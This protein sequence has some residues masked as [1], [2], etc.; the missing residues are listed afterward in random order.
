MTTVHI[1]K[2]RD[3]GRGM[4]CKNQISII[5]VYWRNIHTNW[6]K[7]RKNAVTCWVIDYLFKVY[8]VCIQAWSF[9]LCKKVLYCHGLICRCSEKRLVL[10][11]NKSVLEPRV[12]ASHPT[13]P[14]LIPSLQLTME[15]DLGQVSPL[16]W[17]LCDLSC[18]TVNTRTCKC[19]IS[20]F[21]VEQL[22]SAI[23]PT[24]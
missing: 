9:I 7:I 11:S 8:C 19:L 12:L 24:S 22:A 2:K 14:G 18:L 4:F 21:R 20:V 16:W 10:C 5:G 17:P 15:N 1:V 13:G 6:I 3:P 23:Q